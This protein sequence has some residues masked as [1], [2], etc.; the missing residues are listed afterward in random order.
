MDRKY[1]NQVIS[2][3]EAQLLEKMFPSCELVNFNEKTK[4]I[5]LIKEPEEIAMLRKASEI[6]DIG[7]EAVKKALSERHP[8]KKFTEDEIAGIGTL[9][10]R[11]AGS[12]YE[13]TFTGS[14]E[15][16]VRSSQAHHEKGLGNASKNT[17]RSRLCLNNLKMKN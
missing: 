8:Q 1:F 17:C 16:G 7:N 12:N 6:S 5:Q 10:M 14:Q 2:L 4:Q 3:T 11:K 9:A 15:I 13:W